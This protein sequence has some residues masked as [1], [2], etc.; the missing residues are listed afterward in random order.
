MGYYDYD[1]SFET[2]IYWGLVMVSLQVIFFPLYFLALTFFYVLPLV[3]TGVFTL[4]FIDKDGTKMLILLGTVIIFPLPYVLWSIRQRYQLADAYEHMG[5]RVWRLPVSIKVFYGIN[6][7]IVLMFLIP[8]ISPLLSLMTGF[9]FGAMLS[10]SREQ[11]YFSKTSLV[12]GLLYLPIPLLVSWAFYSGIV[13]AFSKLAELWL[14]NLEFMY[15]STILLA[16]SVTLGGAVYLIYEGAKEVDPSV[17]VPEYLITLGMVVLFLI[18]EGFL[19]IYPKSFGD[20]LIYVHWF[21]IVVG[22]VTIGIRVWK[23]LSPTRGATSISGWATLIFFQALNLITSYIPDVD[24]S[25]A[26]SLAIFVAFIVFTLMFIG[27][28]LRATTRF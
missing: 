9:V 5:S 14:S 4:P 6:Y 8:L 24:F 16:D 13:P 23:G 12:F 11:G 25:V 28:Y 1:E 17:E 19:I 15:I 27:S 21:S 7:L 10:K 18:L 20:F 2:G 22:L 3:E 26:K